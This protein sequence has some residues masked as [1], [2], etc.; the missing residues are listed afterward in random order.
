ME[1]LRTASAQTGIYVNLADE[2]QVRQLQNTYPAL[3]LD[4]IT[5]CVNLYGPL[6]ANVI[7]NLDRKL[8]ALLF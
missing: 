5:R 2:L 3:T 7:Y 1:P 6:R 4:Q 8:K